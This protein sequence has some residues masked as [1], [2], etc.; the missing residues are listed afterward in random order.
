MSAAADSP[1]AATPSP[2]K[3]RRAVTAPAPPSEADAKRMRVKARRIADAL[4][5]V[6]PVAPRGF[7]D[8]R[9]DF[10]L[11]VAVVLSAQTTDV[12]V[13]QVTPALFDAADNPA[14]MAALGAERVLEYVRAVGLAPGKSRNIAALSE[15]IVRDHGGAVPRTLAGLESLAGVGRKTASVVLLQAHGV[16]AFPVDTHVHRLACRWGAGVAGNVEAT[17]ALLRQWFPDET[18]WAELHTRIILFGRE[19]CPARKHDMDGCPVCSFAATAEA[20]ALNR[21]HPTKFVASPTHRDP[22]SLRAAPPTPADAAPAAPADAAPSRR[23]KKPR[24]PPP[25]PPSDSGD[26]VPA[27]RSARAAARRAAREA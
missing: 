16:P 8:H 25:P 6:Y 21:A 22:Y 26:A 1:G 5:E 15:Q 7:L 12:R 19:H 20:R 17:E 13:N 18:G 27:R 14:A 23:S 10:T 24:T 9:N 11:L 2:R 4:S 3:K